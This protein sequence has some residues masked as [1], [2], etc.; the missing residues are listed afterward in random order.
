MNSKQ[1]HRQQPSRAWFATTHWSVVLAAGDKADTRSTGALQTLCQT[2]WYPLYAYV[3]Q[4]GYS[5]EDAEDLTQSFFMHLLDKDR[6]GRLTRD[7]GKFRSF[8]LTALNHFLVD[9]WKRASAQKRGGAQQIFR[10]DREEAETRFR[11]EP[12]DT[13]TAERLFEQNWAVTVLNTV[14]EQLQQEQVAQGK[15][16]QFEQLKFSLTGR[17]SAVPYAELAEKM[18]LSQAALKVLV[19]RLRLRYRELLRQEV[20]HTVT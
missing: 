9:Q 15:G 4:K 3:R 17:R 12:V 1:R 7:K 10:L 13:T 20:A 18:K 11:Q 14:F 6:L 16:V 19:H 8:L 2:Y 5:P